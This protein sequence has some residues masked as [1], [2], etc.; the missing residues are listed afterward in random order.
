MTMQH[1]L[2]I[3]LMVWGIKNLQRYF[4]N[5]YFIYASSILF[6]KGLEVGT[7]VFLSFYL[8]KEQF[9]NFEFYRRI[10]EF[11]AIF[12]SF[13]ASTLIMSASKSK[14]SKIGYFKA[15]VIVSL[16][17]V[18]LISPFLAYFNYSFLLLPLIYYAVFFHSNSLIQSFLLVYYDSNKSAQYKYIMAT[19]F[20]VLLVLFSIFY[21]ADTIVYTSNAMLIIAMIYLYR[22]FKKEKIFNFKVLKN[23]LHIYLKKV[24]KS[25][26]V[27]VNNIVTIAFFTTDIF[28]ITWL[29]SD[30]YIEIAN[31]SFV[32]LLTNL[33]LLVSTTYSQV[34]IELLKKDSA[35]TMATIV[36][37]IQKYNLYGMVLITTI[38]FISIQTYFYKY[39]DTLMI[40]V[41]LLFGKYIQSI[42]IPYGYLFMIKNMYFTNMK[43]NIFIL[44][45]NMLFGLLA[46]FYFRL[47]GLVS[48]TNLS[49]LLRYMI[50]KNIAK[51]LV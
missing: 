50:A 1:M 24:Y 15:G 5:K 45:F 28:I 39:N 25:L 6:G 51:E 38:Y 12:I 27:V 23:Y 41:I 8:T 47:Y 48:I 2:H 36:K 32:L 35:L 49:L 31:I 11:G 30:K 7:I 34:D 42:S 17:L 4:K 33:L 13:G 3:K 46:Y 18:F 29:S 21:S 14:V 9:G 19:F 10:L 26:A 43:L 22:V 16:L 20:S 37:K 44:A 40:F